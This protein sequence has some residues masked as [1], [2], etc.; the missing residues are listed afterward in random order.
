MYSLQAGCMTRVTITWAVQLAGSLP[1]QREMGGE[2]QGRCCACAHA[3]YAAAA[4]YVEGRG[5]C[6][7]V[8]RE[9]SV[10]TA[11]L[12]SWISGL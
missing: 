1:W 11:L 8:D 4:M 5:P 6:M 7:T 9:Q 10:A 2:A 12:D 3:A